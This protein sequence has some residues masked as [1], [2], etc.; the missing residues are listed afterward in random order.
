MKAK[1]LRFLVPA[2]ATLTAAVLQSRQGVSRDVSTDAAIKVFE[3]ILGKLANSTGITPAAQKPGRSA[4][5]LG[6]HATTPLETATP[7]QKAARKIKGSTQP[8]ASTRS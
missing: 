4:P 8:P 7:D 1:H 2:A 6:I 3:D 5:A